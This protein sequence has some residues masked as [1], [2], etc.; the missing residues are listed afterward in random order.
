MEYYRGQSSYDP[1]PPYTQPYPAQP[2]SAHPD[3]AHR[4]PTHPCPP[5]PNPPH[6]HSARTSH[7]PAFPP[8]VQTSG[9]GYLQD[10]SQ[11]YAETTNH[12]GPSRSRGTD[13]LLS[14]QKGMNGLSFGGSPRASTSAQSTPSPG[15][16]KPLPRLPPPPPPIPPRPHSLN[17]TGS[18]GE[19]PAPS[20]WA[21]NQLPLPTPPR[22]SIHDY[23]YNAS[24]VSPLSGS[25]WRQ[26]LFA[27]PKAFRASHTLLLPKLQ[28]PQPDTRLFRPHSDPLIP[29]VPPIASPRKAYK[30]PK[31]KISDVIYIDSGSDSSDTHT[32]AFVTSRS[33]ARRHRIT[34]EQPPDR[35]AVALPKP[36]SSTHAQP[37]TPR[38]AKDSVAVQCSGFTQTGAPCKR[39][40][41][42]KAPFVALSEKQ[43]AYVNE[44]DQVDSGTTDDKEERRY[45]KDHAGMI[46]GEPGFCWQ[47]NTPARGI[48]IVFDGEGYAE[49]QIRIMY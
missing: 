8:G 29:T 10:P 46:C 40:V 31:K 44:A 16:D 1:P 49:R 18:Y 25:S 7:T 32:P 34:S 38:K 6:P 2:H 35:P 17:A 48:Y 23:P 45:C 43:G 12:A 15:R 41:K 42:A 28:P 14:I 22:T 33:P 5:H 21:Q 3:A 9:T 4:Y 39:L 19:Q 11:R 30:N 24:P 36:K 13:Y 20:H 37:L 47:G 27:P 26:S